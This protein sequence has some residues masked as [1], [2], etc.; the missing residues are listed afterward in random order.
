MDEKEIVLEIENQ[1][2][3][4]IN[5]L[6]EDITKVTPELEDLEVTPS[7]IEQKFKSNKY[8]YDNVTVKAVETEELNV[9]SSTENQ[10][11]S[12]LF[13]KV[14]IAKIETEETTI[15]PSAETQTKQGLFNKVTV[16]GDEDLKAEN[17]KAG[18][19]IFGVNGTF[20]G[21]GEE[22]EENFVYSLNKGSSL[23]NQITEIKELD[24]KD[25]TSMA[26]LFNS[27][28][29][30]TKIGVIKNTNKVTNATQT[31]YN[32]S[33]LAEI[34]LF[35]TGNITTMYQ[36]FYG[37][38]KLTELPL[39]D[40]SKVDTFYECFRNCTEL[41]TIPQF[42][43]SNA[44]VI[45][46]MFYNCSKLKNIPSL[47]TS[48]ATGMNS[49]FYGCKLLTELP[50]FDTSN[51]TTMGNAFQA[52][53]S[54]T[55]IPQFDTSNVTTANA[56]FYGCSSLITIP[57]LDFGKVITVNSL[58][59]G[60]TKLTTL[61]GFKNLGKAYTQ[62]TT[63][64]SNYALT[65]SACTALTHDSLMNIINNLYDLNVTYNVAGGGT[66]YTQKLILGATNL[67]KLT[68]SEIAIATNKGWTVS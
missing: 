24:F 61:G 62:K 25:S 51:V 41:T 4:I 46:Y 21:G 48:K 7:S 64:Y 67:A 40:T 23:Q 6:E 9:T 52:C 14:N 27:W 33:A 39:F 16:N 55:E 15:T 22:G 43:I 8:G 37:C 59:N 44:T 49:I 36:T 13:G 30:L 10:T 18:V 32:C 57:E 68:D 53:T 20:E 2:E 60:N 54:L 38:S 56:T 58:F 28:N 66:L 42:N 34:P 29:A 12:G 1:G 45:S 47:N 5:V 63:G 11:Y 31:F 26:N 3:V 17:I 50:L 65:L 35:D 19:N